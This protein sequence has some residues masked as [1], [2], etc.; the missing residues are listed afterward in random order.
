[1]W[2]LRSLALVLGIAFLAGCDE[3]GSHNYSA[4]EVTDALRAHGFATVAVSSD[5]AFRD[6]LPQGRAD[7]RN[8]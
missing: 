5:P 4:Q 8:S 7:S 6:L 1:V 2:L 3:S